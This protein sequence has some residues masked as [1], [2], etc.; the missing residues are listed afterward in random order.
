MRHGSEKLDRCVVLVKSANKAEWLTYAQ[1][2]A[3]RLI[4]SGGATRTI[5]CNERYRRRLEI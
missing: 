2:G 5:G 1:A 3:P 4:R